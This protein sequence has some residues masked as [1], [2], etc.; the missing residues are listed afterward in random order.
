MQ[1]NQAGSNVSATVS[2]TN[3]GFRRTADMINATIDKTTA[4]GTLSETYNVK[5]IS[6]G[7]A[8]GTRTVS[9]SFSATRR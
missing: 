5:T 3:I 9:Y 4:T 7:S 2:G 8:T 6:D 1:A